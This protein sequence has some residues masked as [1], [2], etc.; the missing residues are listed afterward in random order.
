MKIK[1]MVLSTILVVVLSVL[2]ASCSFGSILKRVT[3]G[4]VNID[5]DGKVTIKGESGEFVIGDTK[6]DNKKMHGFDAPKAK[7]TS[8]VITD[9]GAMFTFTEL[10]AK[11]ADDYIDKIKKAGFTYNTFIIENSTYTGT[12]KDGLTM[13]FMYFKEDDAATGDGTVISSKGDPPSEEEKDNET[14]IGQSDKKWDN[15]D[16]G[17]LPDP[18][19]KIISYTLS[20]GNSMYNL[21]KMSDPKDYIEKIK[22]AGFTENNS[23][24][25]A[26]GY[27]MFS[28]SDSDGNRVEFMAT[29]EST[30]INYTEN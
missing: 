26:D 13:S 16:V 5:K 20:S 14:I 3:D 1:K 27:V 22:A 9:D 4:N 10:K 25:E 7:I 29:N 21:E 8:S 11:D 19:V 28:A 18:K 17:G 23:I 6:W 15:N 12:N 24:T 30:L 2:L